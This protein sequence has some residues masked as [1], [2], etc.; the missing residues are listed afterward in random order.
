[1]HILKIEN[2]L[3]F[4]MDKRITRIIELNIKYFYCWEFEFNT[5]VLYPYELRNFYQKHRLIELE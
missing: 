2:K 5:R 4:M 1:M 3:D